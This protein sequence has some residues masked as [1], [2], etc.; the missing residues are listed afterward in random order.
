MAANLRA[1]ISTQH[2][3]N[4]KQR[5][6]TLRISVPLC[7]SQQCGN[8]GRYRNVNMNNKQVVIQAQIKL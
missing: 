6:A 5:L 1:D 8:Y 4:T 2:L 7:V 3:Y